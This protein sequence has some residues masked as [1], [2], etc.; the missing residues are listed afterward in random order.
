MH[1]N[2]VFVKVLLHG[3]ILLKQML[4]EFVIENGEKI[5]KLEVNLGL[6]VML[7]LHLKRMELNE[8]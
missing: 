5:L 8:V 1:N 2:F 4:L 7:D 6:K 3:I